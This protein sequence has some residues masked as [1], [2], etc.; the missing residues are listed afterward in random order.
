MSTYTAG[1]PV[2]GYESR[3]TFLVS[4]SCPT[5]EFRTGLCTTARPIPILKNLTRRHWLRHHPAGTSSSIPFIRPQRQLRTQV[6]ST[7]SIRHRLSSAARFDRVHLR[8]AIT[9][10]R[11]VALVPAPQCPTTTAL[12]WMPLILMPTV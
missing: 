3:A 11:Q 8:T 6:L 4:L 2:R 5:L 9:F 10:I 12:I 7:W 1:W